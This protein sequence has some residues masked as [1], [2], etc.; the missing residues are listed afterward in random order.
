MDS[1]VSPLLQELTRIED[2]IRVREA[3]KSAR[4]AALEGELTS[5]LAEI[6]SLRQAVAHLRVSRG[7]LP[8]DLYPVVARA[9]A[10]SGATPEAVDR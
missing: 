5:L 6:R 4:E 1:P 7:P 10:E 8:A 9:M 2:L 3:Q